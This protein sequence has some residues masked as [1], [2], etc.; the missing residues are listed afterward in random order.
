MIGPDQVING[1]TVGAIFLMLGFVP[2]LLDALGEGLDNCA[3]LFFYRLGFMRRARVA[4]PGPR[5]FTV[6][7]VVLIV[8]T[9][10]AYY[11]K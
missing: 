8:L 3:C 11:A 6:T 7:G 1:V 10:A 4:G 5:W 2:G 9:F